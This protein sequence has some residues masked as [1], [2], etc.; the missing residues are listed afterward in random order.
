MDEDDNPD[1]DMMDYPDNPIATPGTSS[2]P[3]SPQFTPSDQL[4]SCT[5]A[6]VASFTPEK[7]GRETDSQPGTPII[8]IQSVLYGGSQG[9][10]GRTF[11]TIEPCYASPPRV[12]NV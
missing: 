2:T 7:S 9:Q 8:K 11:H 3:Q 10:S 12:L 4:S 5:D 6:A 1:A